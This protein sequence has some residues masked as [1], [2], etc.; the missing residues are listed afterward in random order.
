MGKKIKFWELV[1][2]NMSALYGIRWIAR[3][4]SDSFGLGLGAIVIW[5]VF[6]FIFF[7][8]QAFMCGELSAA[9]NTDGGVSDWVKYAFG[10][11]WGFM[12]SWLRWTSI[13]FWFGSFLT[14]LSINLTYMIGRPDLA[15]NKVVVLAVSLVIIWLLSLASVKGMTFGKIFTNAGS[16]G[17]ILPTVCLILLSFLAIVIL[18]KAPSASVYTAASL[19][20]KADPNSLVGISGIIFAYTGAEIVACYVTEMENPKKNF[21]RAI[22]ISAVMV[23]VLYVLGSIAITMLLPTSEIRASTGILDAIVRASQLLGIPGIFVQIV[24]AGISMATIGALIL[25]ISFPI[26][27]LFGNAEEGLFPERLTK[28]NEHGIP[29]KA[30]LLQAVLITVLLGGVALLPGVDVIYNV[31]V[32]MTSLSCLFPC[33]LLFMAYINFKKKN[34][35]INQ[36][37][38][39]TKNTGLA[40]ALGYMELIVCAA[41]IVLTALPIMPTLKD[42][43]IYEL[44]LV[45]GCAVVIVAG[46]YIWKRSGLKNERVESR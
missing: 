4:T 44:E 7:I 12:I 26:K 9:Y 36:T 17:S 11:K 31:L 35:Y 8:P 22:V 14:F 40:V 13:L 25:Y 23:C 37:F 24:A 45:G 20:P 16:L 19:T 46:L 27:M 5:V 39:M 2:M 29:Q 32:M 10:T 30:I 18:R 28:N 6:M 34:K 3:S 21:P 42:N 33:V 38:V 15:N 43:I 1:L 41:A